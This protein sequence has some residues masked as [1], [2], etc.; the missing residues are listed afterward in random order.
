MGHQDGNEHHR[1]PLP[2]SEL[3][4]GHRGG[5]KVE[6][7]GGDRSFIFSYID[8]YWYDNIRMTIMIIQGI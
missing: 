3:D 4:F 1:M 5:V 8:Y 2:F 7:E 6:R